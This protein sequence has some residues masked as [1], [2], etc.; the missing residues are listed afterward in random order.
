MNSNEAIWLC[1]VLEE[2]EKISLDW[3][4]LKKYSDDFYNQGKE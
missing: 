1:E 2:Q 3:R 4:V